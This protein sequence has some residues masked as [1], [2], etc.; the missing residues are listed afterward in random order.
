[1]PILLHSIIAG[2]IFGLLYGLLFVFMQ[3]RA[4]L[5]HKNSFLFLCFLPT[6][7]LFLFVSGMLLLLK[8]ASIQLMPF[9]SCFGVMFFLVVFKRIIH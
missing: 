5:M 9:L 1:M 6:I 8:M 2:I 3:T 4:F 7:R